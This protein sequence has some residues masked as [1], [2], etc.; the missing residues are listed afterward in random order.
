MH[1]ISSMEMLTT[2]L[3]FSTWLKEKIP[4]ET[5][6]GHSSDIS[7]DFRVPQRWGQIPREYHRPAYIN[8]II[9]SFSTVAMVLAASQRISLR[10]R[11]VDRW[12]LEETFRGVRK[13]SVCPLVCLSCPKGTFSMKSE[14]GQL[15]RKWGENA[16]EN[17]KNYKLLSCKND[18]MPDFAN[19]KEFLSFMKLNCRTVIICGPLIKNPWIKGIFL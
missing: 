8:Q 10:C 16:F 11:W 19:V 1:S 3:K 14:G 9:L 2:K 18:N 7:N 6:Q 12:W 5:F 13:A 4:R 15:K 17:H